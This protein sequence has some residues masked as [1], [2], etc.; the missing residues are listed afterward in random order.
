VV[1]PDVLRTLQSHD[2]PGNVRELRNTLER[3]VILADGNRLTAADVPFQG[4]KR[5]AEAGS[6]S[7]LD[8]PTFE[9][10]KEESEKAY[11]RRQLDRHAW[12]IQQTAPARGNGKRASDPRR[13]SRAV[14]RDPE[15][16]PRNV[17]SPPS[18]V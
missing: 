3:M 5:S 2:W 8:A 6:S 1:D 10:F 13:R 14:R 9:E 4:A 18:G 16:K 17:N 7:F 12:N 11:L 15:G